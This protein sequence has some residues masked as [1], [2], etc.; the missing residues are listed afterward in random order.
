MSLYVLAKITCWVLIVTSILE[1]TLSI[2]LKQ[3]EKEH[4]ENVKKQNEVLKHQNK[5]MYSVL[6]TEGKKDAENDD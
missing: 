3:Y 4:L 1:I 5:V 6:F 2:V